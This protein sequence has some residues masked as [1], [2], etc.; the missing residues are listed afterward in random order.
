[1]PGAQL[2]PDSSLSGTD[3]VLVLGK[4]FKGLASTPT[5]TTGAA[6]GADGDDL[7]ARSGLSVARDGPPD[8]RISFR[9]VRDGT[10]SSAGT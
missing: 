2:V 3:V 7:V 9:A 5:A 4:N 6:D 1:M 10:A 8:A